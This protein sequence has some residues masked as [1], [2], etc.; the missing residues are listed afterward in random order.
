M[1]RFSDAV[2]SERAQIR[3]GGEEEGD[4]ASWTVAGPAT[5][6]PAGGSEGPGI[7]TTG[8]AW[9]HSWRP[10]RRRFA[11]LAGTY[12]TSKGLSTVSAFTSRVARSRK[13]LFQ[14]ARQHFT[15]SEVFRGGADRRSWQPAYGFGDELPGGF[16]VGDVTL[17]GICGP[18]N[19]RPT[20]TAEGMIE[21][22]KATFKRR[23]AGSGENP[24][25]VFDQLLFVGR[26]SNVFDTSPLTGFLGIR[27]V[28]VDDKRVTLSSM[29]D[30]ADLAPGDFVYA[31]GSEQREA[32]TGKVTDSSSSTRRAS[33]L[34]CRPSSR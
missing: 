3:E 28:A 4:A 25:I 20:A 19:R 15:R 5:S 7:S 13:R 1:R 23:C 33:Q 6:R 16:L 12:F 9:R 30:R 24:S 29:S 27:P 8:W 26:T 21:R 22:R 11:R 14:T 17:P 18:Q 2:D 32:L 10:S 31:A 34:L